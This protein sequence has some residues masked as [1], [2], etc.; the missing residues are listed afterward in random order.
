M[1]GARSRA[2][3]PVRSPARPADR[4]PG[5]SRRAQPKTTRRRILQA[6]G[7]LVVLFVAWLAAWILASYFSFRDGV[8]AANARLPAGAKKALTHKGGMLFDTSTTILLL[9]TDHAT[10]SGRQSSHRSDSIMLMRTD[11]AHDRIY[12]LSIP[13][14][15]YVADPA[16]TGRTGS[17]PPTSS[18]ARRSRSRRSRTSRA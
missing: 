10:F 1:A 11:P 2:S 12:Y 18:G 6:V 13:R 7:I 5:Q 4:R 15:L 16:H 3:A 9:G 14:D 17:T 8:D